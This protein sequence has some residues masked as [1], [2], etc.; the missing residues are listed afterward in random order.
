[1]GGSGF[2]AV[3]MPAPG[4]FAHGPGLTVLLRRGEVVGERAA[5]AWLSGQ[6]QLPYEVSGDQI[7]ARFDAVALR[8]GLQLMREVRGPRLRA[9][10]RAGAGL[11]LVHVSPQPG[12][13][14][15][16]AALAPAHWTTAVAATAGLRL[17]VALRRR[18]QIAIDLFAD[19]FPTVVHYDLATPGVTSTVFSPWRVRPG[20][21]VDV[22]IP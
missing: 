15:R 9:G 17:G 11:D 10:V 16:T 21:A 5:S 6:Y 1:L 3:Q 19:L 22:A 8:A 14:D 20:I 4:R 12:T 13:M 18:M 7:G 2:Y